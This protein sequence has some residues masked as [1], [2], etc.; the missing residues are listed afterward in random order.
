MRKKAVF[1]KKYRKGGEKTAEA[2]W[3]NYPAPGGA[4]STKVI[5]FLCISIYSETTIL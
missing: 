5:D 4:I 2:K 1:F 3:K